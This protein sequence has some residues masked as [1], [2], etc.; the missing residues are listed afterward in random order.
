MPRDALY[1]DYGLTDPSFKLIGKSDDKTAVFLLPK[2]DW[3][4]MHLNDMQ[5]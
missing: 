3:E 2:E 1:Q 4:R 5:E